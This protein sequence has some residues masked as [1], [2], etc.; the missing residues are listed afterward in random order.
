MF[1]AVVEENEQLHQI[2]AASGVRL[3]REIS[4]ILVELL[5]SGCSPEQVF[6]VLVDM[7]NEKMKSFLS[8]VKRKN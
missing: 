1:S 8:P 2:A 6:R 4:A 5:R 7:K 3:E